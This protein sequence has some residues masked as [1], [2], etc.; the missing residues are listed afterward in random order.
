MPNATHTGE[1]T[2]V[3]GGPGTRWYKPSSG[4]WYTYN[5]STEQWDLTQDGFASLDVADLK[6]SGSIRVGES[7]G[8]SGE[9]EGEIK[10]ITVV[11]GV[12]TEIELN[13]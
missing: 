5:V 10:K 2:P 4:E 7:E 6:V 12:I 3:G 11:N 13:E 1:E 9:F 8:V